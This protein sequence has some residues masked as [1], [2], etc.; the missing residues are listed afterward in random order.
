MGKI[1]GFFKFELHYLVARD[2]PPARGLAGRDAGG[3]AGACK[4]TTKGILPGQFRPQT[5]V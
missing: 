3:N 4:P 2:R 5:F 1:G